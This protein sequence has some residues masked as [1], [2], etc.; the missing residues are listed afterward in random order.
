MVVSGL[1]S[2]ES[3]FRDCLTTPSE[4]TKN[5]LL[6]GG[7]IVSLLGIA[8]LCA[9]AYAFSNGSTNAVTKGMMDNAALTAGLATGATVI[10]LF[11][12]SKGFELKM[13]KP[14][15]KAEATQSGTIIHQ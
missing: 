6:I 2:D 13:K 5:S 11:V 7:S 12:F 1:K 3:M 10:G 14:E 15:V 9:L 8:A 4:K